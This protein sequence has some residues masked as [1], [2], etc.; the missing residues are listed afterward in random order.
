MDT[1]HTADS[2]IA[3]LARRRGLIATIR[4]ADPFALIAID[5]GGG[6]S[7][8]Q[9]RD[10]G[11]PHPGSALLCRIAG[12]ESMVLYAARSMSARS[13]SARGVVARTMSA[14]SMSARSTRA[15]TA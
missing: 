15:R 4:R 7:A 8:R 6:D 11:S 5:E 13:M 12:T 3:T 10:Q 1:G 9:H 2:E 14:R